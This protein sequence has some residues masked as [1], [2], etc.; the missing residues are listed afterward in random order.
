MPL[1][2]TARS[3][4]GAWVIP[5]LDKVPIA[6]GA[7]LVS[8]RVCPSEEQTRPLML[9]DMSIVMRARWLQSDESSGTMYVRT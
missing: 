1:M 4:E 9:A 5:C 6:L 7:T 3:R 2:T 8:Y